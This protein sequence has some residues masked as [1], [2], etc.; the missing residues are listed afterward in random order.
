[1][2]VRK[3]KSI[4]ISGILACC[5]FMI[6]PPCS[7][8]ELPIRG[9][10]I[11][12]SNQVVDALQSQTNNA[13]SYQYTGSDHLDIT[14]IFYE[15]NYVYLRLAPKG[16]MNAPGPLFLPKKMRDLFMKNPNDLKG[17]SI[18]K[19]TRNTNYPHVQKLR[20]DFYDKN[21]QKQG[22]A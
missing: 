8:T 18:H 6:A 2:R 16:T 17:W 15:D 11:D 21:Q 14:Q 12:S 3:N 7:A 10:I 13:T 5:S 22:T 1:M 19:C 4:V 20:F 9:N